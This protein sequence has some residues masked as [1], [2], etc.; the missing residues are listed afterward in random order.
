MFLL[1]QPRAILGSYWAIL[2]PSWDHLGPILNH[3]G[4]MLGP[5]WAILGHLGP[6]IGP[7]WSQDGPGWPQDDPG[8]PQDGPTMAQ[9]GPRM[10]QD[11]VPAPK[12]ALRYPGQPQGVQG[13][14]SFGASGLLSLREASA[15]CAKRV[16]LVVPQAVARRMPE[17]S[18]VQGWDGARLPG[19][20]LHRYQLSSAAAAAA[21]GTE[22]RCWF[23]RTKLE[24]RD[25]SYYVCALK[26]LHAMYVLQ[27]KMHA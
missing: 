17:G 21:S 22:R 5:S 13:R 27:K 14:L 25:A 7:G 24:P 19:S 26:T 11:G 16:Q 12:M 2:G 23:S 10:S 18:R 8:W 15:G 20:H 9:E 3:L 4:G 1:G 6:R